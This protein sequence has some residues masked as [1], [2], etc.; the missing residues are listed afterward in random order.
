[1]SSLLTEE[2]LVRMRRVQ[3]QTKGLRERAVETNAA[4]LADAIHVLAGA[5]LKLA[6]ALEKR[7]T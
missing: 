7:D 2:D 3:A 1:M 4:D 6:N 5:I